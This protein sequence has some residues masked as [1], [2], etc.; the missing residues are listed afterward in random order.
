MSN[1]KPPFR[2]YTETSF[3]VILSTLDQYMCHAIVRRIDP[4]IYINLLRIIITITYLPP[5]Q[6]I[7]PSFTPSAPH[8]P[9]EYRSHLPSGPDGL[10]GKSDSNRDTVVY[11]HV[12]SG[13]YYRVIDYLQYERGKTGSSHHTPKSQL[14]RT[15]FRSVP[16]V[17]TL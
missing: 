2:S 3:Q 13:R 8:I 10:T 9:L 16:E 4:S 12:P 6:G 11:R 17:W 15:W 5:H 7:L 14:I 1:K